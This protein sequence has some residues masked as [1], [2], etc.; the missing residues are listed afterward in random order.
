MSPSHLI[1]R[2]VS[3]CVWSAESSVA[4]LAAL[5]RAPQCVVRWLVVVVPLV[6]RDSLCAGVRV[7]GG[8][9]LGRWERRGV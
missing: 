6:E 4:R 8:V 2:E 1:S 7:F 5:R 9:G 3:S